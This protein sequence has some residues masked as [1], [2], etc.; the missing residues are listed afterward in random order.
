MRRRRD[1]CAA[2]GTVHH[3]GFID[4][5]R[6]P[7]E[8]LPRDWEP[9]WFWVAWRGPERVQGVT[10]SPRD[11]ALAMWHSLDPAPARTLGRSPAQLILS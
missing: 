5:V 10:G 9:E 11:A 3:G 4:I 7:A 1:Y 2:W 6:W 8:A